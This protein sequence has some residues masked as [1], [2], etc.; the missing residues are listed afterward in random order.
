MN[1]L[2]S[3]PILLWGLTA[4]A[5]PILIHLLRRR[6]A[7]ERPL[8]TLRF[9]AE[10]HKK[11]LMNIQLQDLLL[12]ILRTLLILLLVLALAGPKVTL[13]GGLGRLAGLMGGT[14]ARR[15]ILLDTSRSMNYVEPDGST[16]FQRAIET[17]SELLDE[18]PGS[19]EILVAPFSDGGPEDERQLPASFSS[20]QS[21][22]KRQLELIEPTGRAT[23]VEWAVDRAMQRLEEAADAGIF[24]LTDM[25]ASG[26]E[27]FLGQAAPGEGIRKPVSVVDVG[28]GS[29]RN[30]WISRIDL[31]ALPPGRSEMNQ[32]QV[33]LL[34]Q[35]FNGEDAIPVRLQLDH[36]QTAEEQG[37]GATPP[38][39]ER[40]G[41]EV[42]LEPDRPLTVSIPFSATAE[43]VLRAK[44]R[45][46]PLEQVDPLGA[47]NEVDLQIPVFQEI[48]VLVLFSSGQ[49]I[50]PFQEEQLRSEGKFLKTCLSLALDVGQ[51]GEYANWIKYRFL[52][53]LEETLPD[54]DDVSVVIL[55]G[56]PGLDRE[57]FSRLSRF[58]REGGGLLL[59]TD[60]GWPGGRPMAP[61]LSDWLGELGIQVSR[62]SF[63]SNPATL[64]MAGAD[65][66]AW[67]I[68][69]QG[70]R[71][72]FDAARL[73]EAVSVL[74]PDPEN[75]L[76]EARTGQ[77][78]SGYQVFPVISETALDSGRM[79]VCGIPLR[80]EAG[81]LATLAL[82]VPMLQQFLKY[83]A[84]EPGMESHSSLLPAESNLVQLSS[85]DR[86]DLEQR[87]QFS[88][89]Q[90]GDSARAVARSAGSRDLTGLLL[91]LCLVLALGELFLANSLR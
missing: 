3:Y 27:S 76:A 35:G 43:D 9:L 26:W 91:G 46:M 70:G 4:A 56:E 59:F 21:Y 39:L 14:T 42:T 32:L 68:F 23:R 63:T 15:V 52:D 25:Q 73:W 74:P 77:A 40:L 89:S 37:Q 45:L 64:S 66:P 36:L 33:E 17:A 20:D 71:G 67:K 90:A 5:I 11:R 78:T 51:G 2:F 38:P 61:D 58:V 34:A 88:F 12:L 7:T 22:W 30:L 29:S 19:T 72:L 53:P 85:E 82:W 24:L 8:P 31:P 16:R 41:R 79:I 50:S 81:N 80:R 10:A 69:R 54:L 28:R 18:L 84:L 49:E 86:R 57:G 6:Q 47:D 65:H 60:P 62:K 75:V 87:F 48:P 55:Y 13:S 1:I 83:L 44:L